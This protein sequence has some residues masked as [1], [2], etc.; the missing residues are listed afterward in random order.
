MP[1]GT[2]LGAASIPTSSFF[3]GLSPLRCIGFLPK[4]SQEQGKPT[5]PTGTLRP[6]SQGPA[7]IPQAGSFSLLQ[8]IFSQSFSNFSQIFFQ[9]QCPKLNQVL[10]TKGLCFVF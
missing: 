6:H 4:L 3:H 2:A 8:I 7:H 9:V 1:M 10:F 5:V